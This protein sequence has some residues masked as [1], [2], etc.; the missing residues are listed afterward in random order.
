MDARKVWR[1]GMMAGWSMGERKRARDGRTKADNVGD[2]K[3]GTVREAGR[4]REEEQTLG[5][6]GQEK[7]VR[8][9]EGTEGRRA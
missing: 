9:I 4:Q 1:K 2:R 7:G 5:R 6:R 8:R 3:G